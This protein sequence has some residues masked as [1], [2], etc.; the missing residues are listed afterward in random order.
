METR[1][2]SLLMASGTAMD[3]PLQVLVRSSVR[4]RQ[5]KAMG[6]TDRAVVLRGAMP[7]AAAPSRLVELV[8]RAKSRCQC[9]GWSLRLANRPFISIC[10]STT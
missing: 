4:H 3:S 10:A 5:A 9:Q 7:E 2:M 6:G 1:R 8:G